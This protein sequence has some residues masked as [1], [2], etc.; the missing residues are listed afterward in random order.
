MWR[1]ILFLYMEDPLQPKGIDCVW[2]FPWST[3]CP[4]RSEFICWVDTF[5]TVLSFLKYVI[6]V[7][8]VLICDSEIFCYQLCGFCIHFMQHAPHNYFGRGA[9]LFGGISQ[10][11]WYLGSGHC[12]SSWVLPALWKLP[13][14]GTPAPALGLR[15]AG[16]TAQ[17]TGCSW[18]R[19][20]SCRP[21]LPTPARST[22]WSSTGRSY[23]L[24]SFL[25]PRC[26]LLSSNR[27]TWT[28]QDLRKKDLLP[29]VLS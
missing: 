22:R 24:P 21:V 17:P 28:S 25:S 26:L 20:Q 3:D 18:H 6:I 16:F 23:L 13:A 2:S 9:L 7:N 8:D 4:F 10:C 14:S 19:P 27:I 11:N 1:L 15:E 5:F 12:P 29:L